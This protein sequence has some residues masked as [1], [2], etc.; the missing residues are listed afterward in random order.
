MFG[1][2]LNKATRE[3]RS[4]LDEA[5]KIFHKASSMTGDKA[6]KL[7]QQGMKLLDASLSKAQDMEKISLKAGE[8]SVNATSAL[9]QESPWRAIA[10]SG[11]I[12]ASIGLAIGMS[13]PRK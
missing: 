13:I 3:V 12:A 7:Q 5:E 1:S 6:E 2:N 11:A 10:I 4:L 8:K 9:I